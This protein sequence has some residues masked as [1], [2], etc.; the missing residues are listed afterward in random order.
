MSRSGWGRLVREMLTDAGLPRAELEYRVDG[1]DG[2]RADLDLA[3]PRQ[4]LGI[5]LD[6]ATPHLNRTSFEEDPRRR[7]KLQNLGWSILDFTWADCIERSD[8]LVT[9]V[10][11]ALGRSGSDGVGFRAMIVLYHNPN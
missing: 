3:C 11:T 9:T 1:R 5:E 2:F 7:N 8:E 4:Q 6:S 10:R